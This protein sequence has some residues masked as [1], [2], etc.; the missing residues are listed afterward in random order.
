[1]FVRQIW[2][3]LGHK[4]ASFG[5]V[6]VVSPSGTKSLSHTTPESIEIHALL[7]ALV[8]E[9]VD[10]VAFEASSHGIAQSRVDGVRIQAAGFT[11]LTR[12]HL[13]YH[14]TFEAYEEAKL[15]LFSDVLP[16]DGVAVINTDSPSAGR[17]V[18]MAQARGQRVLRVG[19]KGH[20]LVLI[21]RT[22]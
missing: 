9:G 4:A 14:E 1:S 22:A 17:F 19:E 6:G 20:E 13:D 10:H 18:H 3:R 16:S 7:A 12:D 5:T 15:R 2:E 11:N 8:D 21:K